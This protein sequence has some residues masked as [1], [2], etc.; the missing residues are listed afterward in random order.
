MGSDVQHSAFK[1]RE[2]MSKLG[3]K[4]TNR[5]AGESAYVKRAALALATAVARLER[6]A[7]LVKPRTAKQVRRAVRSVSKAQ[8]RIARAAVT[9][10]RTNRPRVTRATENTDAA[11]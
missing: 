11:A 8:A 9:C 2:G 3:R 1:S 6:L 7:R 4:R 5:T 10:Y